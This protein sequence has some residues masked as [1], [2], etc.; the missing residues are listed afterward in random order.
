MKRNMA[1]RASEV[2]FLAF[3][4]VISALLKEFRQALLP[5]NPTGSETF[6]V[7]PRDSTQNMKSSLGGIPCCRFIELPRVLL[8]HEQEN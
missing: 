1:G 4:H 7:G 5:Q 2:T 8:G 6:P 3:L